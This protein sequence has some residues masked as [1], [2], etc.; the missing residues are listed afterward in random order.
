MAGGA[1]PPQRYMVDKPA[2]S[3]DYFRVMGIPLLSGRA[4]SDQDSSTAPACRDRQP[5]CGANLLARW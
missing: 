3:S 5:E 2:V 4:F 1:L